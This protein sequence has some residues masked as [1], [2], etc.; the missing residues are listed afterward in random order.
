MPWKIIIE[1]DPEITSEEI[2]Q[3][4]DDLENFL[5]GTGYKEITCKK[6]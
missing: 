3:I 2:D 4:C 1:F 6:E 5:A